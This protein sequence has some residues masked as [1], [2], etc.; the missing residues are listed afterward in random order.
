MILTKEFK[1]QIAKLLGV[2]MRKLGFKG[3]GLTYKKQDPNF[4]Y[5][6]LVAPGT[7]GNYCTLHLY[8]HPKEID[9]NG[10]G[11]LNLEN[12][13]WPD[14]EF[15]TQ[16]YDTARGKRWELKDDEMDNLVTL[17]EIITDIRGRVLPI[18]QRFQKSPGPL[19]AFTVAEMEN[20]N[21]SC[22]RHMGTVILTTH[23]RLAWVLATVFELKN[24]EKAARFAEYGLAQLEPDDTFIGRPDFTRILRHNK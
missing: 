22:L 13:R 17:Q 21:K 10:T 16:L 5:L 15:R 11:S 9:K 19:D 2:E 18:I 23:I 20:I 12:L 7:W 3:T 4:L 1:R 14:Y 6:V 24:P 8:I